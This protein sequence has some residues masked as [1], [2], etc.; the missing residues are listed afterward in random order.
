MTPTR[1]Q[2]KFMS[3]TTQHNRSLALS[4]LLDFFRHPQLVWHGRSVIILL[5]EIAALFMFKLLRNTRVDGSISSDGQR[6]SE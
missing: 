4:C 3:I 2:A 1:P 6:L 5:M